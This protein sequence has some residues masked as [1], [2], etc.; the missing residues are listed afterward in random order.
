MQIDSFDGLNCGFC[1]HDKLTMVNS[2]NQLIGPTCHWLTP[3][4]IFLPISL[5]IFLSLPPQSNRVEASPGWSLV[6]QNRWRWHAA[7]LML[8][9]RWLVGMDQPIN[10]WAIG[11]ETCVQPDGV[12]WLFS[13]QKNLLL[14]PIRISKSIKIYWTVIQSMY[15]LKWANRKHSSF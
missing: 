1:W 9:R 2:L 10:D 5:S 14:L 11:Q 13:C 8:L 4:L 6:L 12:E 3:Q 7:L 15:E